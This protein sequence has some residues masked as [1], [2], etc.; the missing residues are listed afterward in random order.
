[1]ASY[2][3]IADDNLREEVKK[4]RDTSNSHEEI[5]QRVTDG[6]G[7]PT[8]SIIVGYAILNASTVT[9]VRFQNSKGKSLQI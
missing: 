9:T 6:L 5:R 2:H 3:D 7:L 1:M 8:S 4:I